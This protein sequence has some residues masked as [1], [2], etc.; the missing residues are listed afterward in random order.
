M[1]VPRHLLAT[2]TFTPLYGRLCNVMGR[3]GANQ[4][5]MLFAGLGTIACG[6]S[7]N[8][9]LLIAARFVG[10]ERPFCSGSNCEVAA[11]RNWW[12][13]CFYDFVVRLTFRLSHSHT[14]IS[15]FRIITSDMFS[16]RV[17]ARRQLISVTLNVTAVARTCSGHCERIHSGMHVLL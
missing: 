9:N 2:C 11:R 12:W 7:P 5:A 13:G 17:S 1:T 3:R 4:T 10:I 14:L 6:L 16:L 15:G 8:M